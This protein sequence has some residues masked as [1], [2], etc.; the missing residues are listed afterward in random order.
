MAQTVV[1]MEENTFNP[2]RSTVD[3]NTTVVW[4]NVGSAS[5]V[6]DSIQFHDGADNW[7][8]RTQ[9]L[10]PSDSAVYEFSEEGIYEFY[11]GLQEDDMWCCPCRGRL[12]VSASSL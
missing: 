9:V 1:E 2:V 8:F 3:P 10:R 7:H 6:V 12:I 11:C 4:K 5:H